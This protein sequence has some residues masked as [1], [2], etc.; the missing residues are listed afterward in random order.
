MCCAA[1]L[2]PLFHVRLDMY[3]CNM[4][5]YVYDKCQKQTHNCVCAA[6]RRRR[7]TSLS[8]TPIY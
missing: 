1:A 8:C 7:S 3:R 2:R 6:R 4:S 5:V